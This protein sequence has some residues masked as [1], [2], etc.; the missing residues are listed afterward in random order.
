MSP[1]LRTALAL[2]LA[3]G[4][5]GCA[6]PAPEGVVAHDLTV[7]RARII[8]L[9]Q[10]DFEVG[11]GA[12]QEL[13]REFLSRHAADCDLDGVELVHEQTRRGLAGTYVR[14]G[15]RAGGVPVMGGT[16]VVLVDRQGHVRT[17]NLSH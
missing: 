15:Q 8:Q 14:F 11:R 7:G 6:E 5:A 13:A 17:V 9:R 2:T 10:G 3:I 16:V 12:P 1:P 4:W